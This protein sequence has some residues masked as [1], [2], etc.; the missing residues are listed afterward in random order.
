[1]NQ[2]G[3]VWIWVVVAAGIL[4]AGAGIWLYLN[5]DAGLVRPVE[6]QLAYLKKNDLN[7]AYQ[8]TSNNFKNKTSYDQF[9]K[10]IKS[11]PILTG[12]KNYS[13][14]E[15]LSK[16]TRGCVQ[17][18]LVSNTNQKSTLF[19]GLDKQDKTWLVSVILINPKTQ[20]SCESLFANV[21]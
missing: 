13:V 5:K 1:M 14:V 19:F 7:S 8:M 3:A 15:K 11:Y 18:S 2:K 16:S 20:T 21:K 17:I 9:S 10:T 12:Y 4:L 6:N